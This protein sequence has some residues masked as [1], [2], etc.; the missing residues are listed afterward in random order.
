MAN[1]DPYTIYDAD[2]SRLIALRTELVAYV[3]ALH[4][5]G[6]S[7]H[8]TE[9]PIDLLQLIQQEI[10]ERGR[11]DDIFAALDESFD[12]DRGI[13]CTPFLCGFVTSQ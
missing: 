13:E 6:Y 9:R 3:H 12:L 8:E 11:A 2:E 4:A 7:E 10:E 1:I 5:A